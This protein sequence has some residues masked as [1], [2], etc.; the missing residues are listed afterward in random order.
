MCV[1]FDATG[2]RIRSGVFDAAPSFTLRGISALVGTLLATEHRHLVSD[3]LAS[4]IHGIGTAVD[5]LV[6]DVSEVTVM[7]TI[8]PITQESLEENAPREL[9]V[10]AFAKG[11]AGEGAP[12]LVKQVMALIVFAVI[13]IGWLFAIPGVPIVTA[14]LL[15]VGIASDSENTTRCLQLVFT[16]QGWRRLFWKP[17]F[18]FCFIS[19]WPLILLTC[20]LILFVWFPLCRIYGVD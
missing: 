16:D 14:I 5:G 2:V 4:K 13:L 18:R 6:K 19:C 20:G 8:D 10:V 7:E 11:F 17:A 3:V 9:L 1:P 15:V 12:F